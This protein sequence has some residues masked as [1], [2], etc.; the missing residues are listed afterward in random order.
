MLS[1]RSRKRSK[2]PYSKRHQVNTN[3]QRGLQT[4]RPIRSTWEKC[5]VNLGS[6]H[7]QETTNKRPYF[8]IRCF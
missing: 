4:I 6:D 3:L 7:Q 1:A 2:P 5:S 8:I